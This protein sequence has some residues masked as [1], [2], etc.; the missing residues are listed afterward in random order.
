MTFWRPR[1]VVALL[2]VV[3]LCVMF[4]VRPGANRLSSRIVRTVSLALGRPVEVGWV[5]LRLFP[6]P[7]FD[8]ENFVV[9]D[10]P[11]FSAEPFLRAQNVNAV[12]RLRSLLRGRIEIA[13]LNLSEP[14]LN[15]VRNDAGKWNVENLLERTSKTSVAPTGKS[16]SEKRPGFPYIE[17]DSA[18]INLKLGAEKT[19]FA[20]TDA[21][22]S[23]WQESENS[24]GLRLRATPMR[25]DMNLTD[26]GTLRVE[27]SW[28]R[29]ASL[30]ETPLHFVAHW[31]GG[32][33]GQETKLFYG[34]DKGWRGTFTTSLLL[35]GTPGDLAVGANGSV[36][37]LHRYDVLGGGELDLAAECGAHFSSAD[38]LLSDLSCKAP[39]DDGELGL[40]GDLQLTAQRLQYDLALRA[41]APAQ[42]MVAL[43]RHARNGVPDDLQ[44][45]GRLNTRLRFTQNADAGQAEGDGGINDLRLQSESANLDLLLG[46]LPLTIVSAG[47]RPHS[48]KQPAK[49]GTIKLGDALLAFGPVA[50]P[51]GKTE[52]ASVRGTLS[53]SGYTL[54]LEG[55]AEIP[56][57]LRTLGALGVPTPQVRAEGRAKLDLQMTGPWSGAPGQSSGKVQISSVRAQ[58]Q[59]LNQ[60]VTVASADLLFQPEQIEVQ[61]LRAFAAGAVLAGTMS[62]PRRC[63]AADCV[64]IFD[65]RADR[66]VLEQLNALLNPAAPKQSWYQFLSAGAQGSPYLRNLNAEGKIS[67]GEFIARK[68]T[69]DHVTANVELKDGK[70]RLTN[71]RAGLFNGTHIGE[72]T[73]DFTAKPPSY[74]GTGTLQH[75]ELNDLAQTMDDPWIT[76]VANGTYRTTMAGLSA[77]ELLSSASVI[78]QVNAE[79]GE[80]PHL[81]LRAGEPSAVRKLSAEVLLEDGSIK[82]QDGHLET[83]GETYQ[84]QGSATIERVLNLTLTRNG[85]PAFTVSGTLSKPH[86]EAASETQAALK[87]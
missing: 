71:L 10:D 14:S 37:D 66:V 87:P 1:R 73:A 50:L 22:A 85:T 39:L 3:L 33:L 40:H 67:A 55:D 56:R 25:A 44:A 54:G 30:R 7:G 2:V 18:R 79:N 42:A 27:G 32:Q 62:L 80:L 9:Y 48:K 68:L 78:F 6:R 28:Q 57:L 43:L 53:R 58:A 5:R 45:S 83:A 61:N 17:L 38:H 16:N 4:L 21:D 59:G 26:T 36:R 82:L 69:A 65:L 47:E 41:D 46:D 34:L 81:A 52:T 20:L 70:L 19:P 15:L 63:A 49:K 84:F 8:L 77:S 51:M 76:G 29:A 24:W 60:P 35:S 31:Q 74:S 64:T 12:L 86:V 13:R 72:W 23:L 11:T 75:V